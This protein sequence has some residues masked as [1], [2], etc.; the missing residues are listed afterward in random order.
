MH[1]SIQQILAAR[2]ST[3]RKYPDIFRNNQQGALLIG[4]IVAIV[5]ASTLAA[6][7]VY[8]ISNANLNSLSSNFAKRS[9]YNAEAGFRYL[10]ALY[11]NAESPDVGKL[12]LQNY[13]SSYSVAARTITLPSGGEAVLLVEGLTGTYTPATAAYVSGSGSTLT[14]SVSSG[15][16]PSTIGFFKKGSADTIYRYTGT[17]ASGSNVTL[18]GVYPSITAASGDSFTTVEKAKITSKGKFG[19]LW[20]RTV[21]YEWA[22]SGSKYGV[23][24]PTT[25]Y[26]PDNKDV[27]KFKYSDLNQMLASLAAV[28][29]SEI[30]AIFGMG[31]IS[32]VDVMR[33]YFENHCPSLLGVPLCPTALALPSSG[34]GSPV[35][36]WGSYEW[37]EGQ[38][39][40]KTN[41]TTSWWGGHGGFFLP[42]NYDFKTE[43]SN[44][45]NRLNYDA[46]T[47]MRIEGWNKDNYLVGLS[48]RADSRCWASGWDPVVMNQ[49]GISY[50]RG[51][52]F[53]FNLPTD[54]DP[55]IVFWRSVGNNFK[56][57]AY[58][59]IADNDGVLEG[60]SFFDDMETD[61]NGWT[62]EKTG[63]SPLPEWSTSQY[64]SSSHSR[65]LKADYQ[66]RD[67]LPVQA[68]IKRTVNFSGASTATISFWHKRGS[69]WNNSPSAM[70][71]IY[72]SGSWNTVRSFTPVTADWTK[73]T[74]QVSNADSGLWDLGSAT[75]IRF[76]VQADGGWINRAAEMYIDDVE[77]V[78]HRL[79]DWP[80]LGVRVREKG[81]S[82]N[83]SNEFEIF[84]G[85]TDSST[86]NGTSIIDLSRN[87]VARNENRWLP[88]S[89]INTLTTAQDRLTVVSSDT[90][91][92][93]DNRWY[94]W[95]N[96]AS[97]PTTS[98]RT[99]ISGEPDCDYTL[100]SGGSKELYTVIKTSGSDCQTTDKYYLGTN[101]PEE[102]AIHV[103]SNITWNTWFD[104]TNILLTNRS[105]AYSPGIQY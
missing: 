46:Q 82:P 92:A 74:V 42:Y 55:Y 105:S 24:D 64:H 87:A 53:M 11:R 94:W 65:R 78:A 36:S 15:T 86:G 97:L 66:F 29:I 40:I 28:V 10:I 77:I 44:A 58:K 38:S 25:P 61:P 14:V 91:I 21:T 104:D 85:D 56:L 83:M 70:L 49:Y 4:L 69:V 101:T 33:W 27:T 57:I 84:Y 102:F 76:V 81:T 71:Q 89:P 59:K 73:E 100:I 90:S 1:K 18:T 30:R 12:A 96:G 95:Q 8:L 13:E 93:A 45:N 9:Y 22:L 62:A 43:R 63:H 7:M 19:Y 39:A 32:S 6:G 50:A 48:V 5:V 88:A 41:S 52:N 51:H 68:R 72:G 23:I 47:K 99:H 2:T 37:D 20:N 31:A 75:E 98:P 54:S 34:C 103:Y 26:S 79:K 80:T 60:M 17:S 67:I 16:F 3:D 35:N